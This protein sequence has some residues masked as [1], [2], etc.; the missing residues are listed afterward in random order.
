MWSATQSVWRSHQRPPDQRT[1]SQELGTNA[2][3]SGI[4][5]TFFTGRRQHKATGS[6]ACSRSRFQRSA[7]R[8][9]E[10]YLILAWW[11]SGGA[12]PVG[13]RMQSGMR[14]G[15]RNRRHSDSGGATWVMW[16]VL[17]RA[18]RDPSLCFHQRRMLQGPS[19]ELLRRTYKRIGN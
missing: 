13:C 2:S 3:V 11:R 15:C 4:K 5:I 19:S 6:D 12:A 18:A 10:M 14:S 1:Y 8:N 9:L 16:Q 7:F 17:V